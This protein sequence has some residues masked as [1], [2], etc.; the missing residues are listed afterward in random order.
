MAVK[1]KTVRYNQVFYDYLPQI[2]E[3]PHFFYRVRP[4]ESMEITYEDAASTAMNIGIQPFR[5][6][7]RNRNDPIWALFRCSASYGC[8]STHR[9]SDH[10]HAGENRSENT[11]MVPILWKPWRRVVWITALESL[12]YFTSVG[13][14]KK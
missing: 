5:G 7:Y 1:L 8:R 10:A 12:F 14:P 6:C 4:F 13:V 9:G 3:E 11:E 2:S